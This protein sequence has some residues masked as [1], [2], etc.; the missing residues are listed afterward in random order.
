MHCV[1]Q[2]M[3]IALLLLLAATVAGL[4]IP[5]LPAIRTFGLRFLLTTEWNPVAQV[6]GIAPQ[7]YGTLVTSL[8]AVAIVVLLSLGIAIL[9]VED[10]LPR[11]VRVPRRSRNCHRH[12]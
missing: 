12:L 10:L 1:V 3:A 4:L 6:Y 8:V 9:L 7:I 5:V 11:A 2:G